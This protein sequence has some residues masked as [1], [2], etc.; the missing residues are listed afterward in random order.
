[1]T[2][3]LPG[4]FAF[5]FACLLEALDLP[6]PESLAHLKPNTDRASRSA[7]APRERR[8]ERHPEPKWPETE[9]EKKH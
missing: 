2:I 5:E 4:E 8:V 6:T 9:S 1:M 7:R 3:A